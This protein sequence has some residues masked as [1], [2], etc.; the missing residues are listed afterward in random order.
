MLYQIEMSVSECRLQQDHTSPEVFPRL[1]FLKL[2]FFRA[3]ACSKPNGVMI[4]FLSSVCQRQL[5]G[6]GKHV[7]LS[8][9]QFPVWSYFLFLLFSKRL[10]QSTSFYTLNQSL[11]FVL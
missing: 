10:F 3:L 1:R 6:Q 9:S 2:G 5:Q 7:C 4:V 8:P 11:Q